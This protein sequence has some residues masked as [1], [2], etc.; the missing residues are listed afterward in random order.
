MVVL[1]VAQ[2]LALGHVESHV[3]NHALE[4]AEIVLLDRVAIGTKVQLE[5]QAVLA[6]QQLVHPV[7]AQAV[8]AIVVVPVQGIAQ[9]VVA[10][11]V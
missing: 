2:V 4:L 5:V 11:A 1:V 7:V 9:L 6:A 8:R 10:L 3:L